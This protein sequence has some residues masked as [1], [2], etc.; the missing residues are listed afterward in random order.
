MSSSGK[1]ARNVRSGDERVGSERER[2][3]DR[4]GVVVARLLLASM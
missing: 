2:I 3:S 1:G 4:F